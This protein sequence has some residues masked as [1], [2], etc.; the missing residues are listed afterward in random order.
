VNIFRKLSLSATIF[1]ALSG[2]ALANDTVRYATD[3]YGLGAIIIVASE[4]GFFK[5]QGIDPVIQTYSA[6]IDTVDA[7]L[8]GNA[9]FGVIIDFP[10]L[11][12]FGA[13][14]LISPVV[15]GSPKPGYHK[16]YAK[17][18]LTTKE[19]FT[20]KTFG[21][22]TGTAQEFLT[23]GYIAKLGLDPDKDVK[24]IGFNDQFNI[25]GAMKAGQVDAAWVWGEG[26]DTF[27][28]DTKF[29]LVADD[30]V[31]GQSTSALL[32]TS[33][34]YAS[35]HGEIEVKTLKALA[36]AADYIATDRSSAAQIVAR[37]VGAD[38]EVV[39]PAVE[40][41]RYKLNFSHEAVEGL[42]E[43]YDFLVKAGKIPPYDFAAQFDSKALRS[44][45][46]DAEVDPRLAN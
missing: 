12:R 32:A 45:L 40:D 6:G 27:K 9:D 5:Q 35:K 18:G 28:A 33:K 10:L 34:D 42:K 16:L 25:V 1:A 13:G 46:P 2:S 31:V 44:A 26:A 30:S 22:A 39:K 17:V 4:K 7:V 8:A 3:G 29:A 43:K 41:N 19:G 20:G 21:V 24:L 38:V 15:L 23:R 37:A 36:E 14:K 11:T